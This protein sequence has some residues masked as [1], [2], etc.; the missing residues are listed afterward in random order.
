MAKPEKSRLTSLILW[1]SVVIAIVAIVFFARSFT[2]EDVEVKVVK[3]TYQTLLKTASTNGKV[4]P[5]DEFQA[6]APFSGVIKHIYVSVGDHV[7][8]GT[9]LVRMDDA[10]ANAKLASANAALSAAL[11]NLHDLEHGG[12][13]EERNHYSSDL[14]SATLDQQQAAE[15]LANA[16]KLFARGSASA[17]EVATEQQH[18]NAANLALSTAKQ[19]ST[20]RYSSADTANAQARVAEARANVLAAKAGIAAVDIRSPRAGTVYSIPVSEYDFITAGEDILDVADLTVVQVR[21]Y[22]DEPDIGGL[23]RGQ[24]VA[25]EWPAKPG[26]VW[27]GRIARAPTTVITYGTRNVGECLITVSDSKGDLDP[28]ANV[29][30]TVTETQRDNV[31]SIPREALHTDGSKDFVFRITDG[32]LFRAPVQVGVVNLT[33]VEIVSGLTGTDTIVLGPKS[34]VKELT[35]GLAVKQV[36]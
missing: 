35:N 20:G 8:Q 34:S 36:E 33:N 26:S 19:R 28:N 3:V 6:H 14:S 4:E 2:R 32:K 10:D 21:A 7:A 22:F 9:L 29:T 15:R 13:V 5:V 12:S 18:L 25:V 27:H 1:V 17:G 30:V 16:Q 11:L 31:L 23:A 24:S